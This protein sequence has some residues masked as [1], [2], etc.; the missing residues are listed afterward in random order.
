MCREV[1]YPN[2]MHNPALVMS[3][4]LRSISSP[5]THQSNLITQLCRLMLTEGVSRRAS[6]TP[7]RQYLRRPK[8]SENDPDTTFD[9]KVGC[10]G[11]VL[12]RVTICWFNQL[13]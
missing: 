4:V 13:Q 7:S 3:V 10:D 8:I 6:A 2:L 11:K 12:K 1:C 5:I 9:Q